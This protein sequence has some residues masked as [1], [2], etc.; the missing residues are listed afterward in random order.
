MLQSFLW[1]LVAFGLNS[2]CIP[3]K[4]GWARAVFETATNIAVVS[5][6]LWFLF[7]VGVSLTPT[8]RWLWHVML[9][10]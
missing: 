6:A 9:H 8:F 10:G 5:A 4:K 2:L 3:L 7:A 1:F